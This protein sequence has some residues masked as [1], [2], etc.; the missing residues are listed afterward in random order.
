VEYN[1]HWLTS[2]ISKG[3]LA[4]ALCLQLPLAVQ[5]QGARD[6]QSE[7][8]SVDAAQSNNRLAS[9]SDQPQNI[10]APDSA[11]SPQAAS[12][13][14]SLAAQ[15]LSSGMTLSADEYRA[16]GVGCTGFEADKPYFQN[17]AKVTVVYP[18]SPADKAEIR[19]GDRIVYTE[20]DNEQ[21]I[22]NPSIPQWQVKLGKAGT[23]IDIQ[24]LRHGKPVTLTLVRMNIEDIADAQYRERW[25]KIV[26]DLGY[27]TE[28]TFTGT[29]HHPDYS[30]DSK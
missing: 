22:A 8:P 12:H 27:K 14:F 2:G 11:G 26:R 29:G 30:A 4:A 16:L 28:G 20:K 6:L 9:T 17:I 24:V 15:K 25:E 13:M 7:I 1:N 21:A 3:L 19:K 5:A 23:P 18:G 10:A